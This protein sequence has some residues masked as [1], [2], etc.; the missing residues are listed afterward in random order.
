MKDEAILA[1]SIHYFIEKYAIKNERGLPI[2]FYDRP[3]LWDIYK[4]MS[5]FQAVLKAPQ[6]GLTTLEIIKIMYV[7]KYKGKDIIYT[8]PT[9][10][11]VNDMA[12]GKTN[13]IIAQNPIFGEWVKDHDTVEQ[14][15]VG[16]NIIYFR[17]TFSAKQAMMVASQLNVHDEVDAS[18]AE[19]L[20]QY[21][22][23]QQAEAGGMRWYFSHPSTVGNGIDIYWQKSDMKEWFITCPKCQKAQF[24]EWPISIDQD[25]GCYQCKFC[26]AELSDDDRRMG[27]WRKKNKDAEFSGYHIS[28]LMCAWI[29]ASKIIKDFKEKD[30][31]YFHNFV[32]A[33]PYADNKSKITLEVIKKLLTP[34]HKRRGRVIFGVDTGIKIR[35]CVGDQNGLFD[36]GEVESYEDMQRICDRYEDWIAVFD[37]GGDIVGVRQFAETNIGKVFLCFFDADRKSMQLIRWGEGNEYGKVNVD[38]N[39]LIQLVVDEMTDGRIPL[40]GT[41]EKWWNMWLHWAAMY[42]LIEEDAQGNLKYIWHRNNRNDWAIAMCY[43]RVGIDRFAEA[44]TTFDG[45]QTIAFKVK[46]QPHRPVSGE[47]PAPKIILPDVDVETDWRK[48]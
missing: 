27:E 39:R 36:Y 15:Q 26:K 24:L 19:V 25:R 20:T 12:G 47:L 18:D 44:E 10:T 31:Q 5:P 42:R 35:W 34:T 6:I 37:Q 46:E 30:P 21:E 48:L 1:N 9:K 38:R 40:I 8:L 14:K 7:A 33:L 17:G 43:F 4:D 11:D 16:D 3:F 13:R 23:R 2:V 41:L 22:T 32:L 29:P 45:S 28:Q